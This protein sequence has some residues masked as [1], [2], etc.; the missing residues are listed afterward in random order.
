MTNPTNDPHS[1]RILSAPSEATSQNHSSE[2]AWFYGGTHTGQVRSNNEDRFFCDEARGLF[3]VADGMGGHAAGEEASRIVIETLSDALSSRALEK[4][5]TLDRLVA[6]LRRANRE[7]IRQSES[8]YQWRGMG[9]TAVLAVIQETTLYLAH[10][11]DSRAY[12][13]RAGQ[14]H[15]LS[16][17]HSVAAMLVRQNEIRPEEVRTHALRNRLTMCLGIEEKIQ[18]ETLQLDLESG[19]RLLLCSDG[20]WDMLPDQEI[21]QLLQLHSAPQDAVQALIEAAN[22]AGGKDNVTAVVLHPHILADLQ[23]YKGGTCASA[24]SEDEDTVILRTAPHA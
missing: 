21:S 12:V 23:D 22:A 15:P 7:V 6:V 13:L 16:Q 1:T 20:L 3:V 8:N 2:E 14:L 5:D 24:A 4:C 17:D 10:V 18:P 11:G 9:S 19:D